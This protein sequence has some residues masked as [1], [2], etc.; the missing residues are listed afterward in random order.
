MEI[1]KVLEIAIL[2]AIGVMGYLIHNMI[3]EIKAHIRDTSGKLDVLENTLNG[4]I[5]DIQEK[6]DGQVQEVRQELNGLKS[7]LPFIYATQEDFIRAMSTVDDKLDRIFEHIIRRG[8]S[9][10]HG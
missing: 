4:K 2:V 1:S 10:G 9:D 7:D 5:E 6:L 3:N 8:N